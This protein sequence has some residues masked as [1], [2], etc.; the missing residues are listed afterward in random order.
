MRTS[1][2]RSLESCIKDTNSRSGFLDQNTYD[3]LIDYMDRTEK[4][5]PRPL[6][7]KASKNFLRSYLD[8]NNAPKVFRK[9][10]SG[11]ATIENSY[12]RKAIED[13]NL[14]PSRD[15]VAHSVGVFLIGLFLISRCTELKRIMENWQSR[16]EINH[17]P[18]INIF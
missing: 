11:L 18:L 12:R 8:H 14:P 3:K 9:L 2:N 6:Y 1:L 5:V 4:N 16:M 13:N 15:H 17:F 10:M 7:H